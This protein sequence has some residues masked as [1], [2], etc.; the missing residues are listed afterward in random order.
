MLVAS[1]RV[2][3]VSWLAGN[4]SLFPSADRLRKG[5]ATAR[6]KHT[7][8]HATPVQYRHNETWQLIH[9]ASQAPIDLLRIPIAIEVVARDSLTIHSTNVV[10][11][12]RPAAGTQV[13]M[14]A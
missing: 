1:I 10:A 12:V 8:Q 6:A 7:S 14:V 9:P 4:W 11:I 3:W 2:E 13:V 5:S